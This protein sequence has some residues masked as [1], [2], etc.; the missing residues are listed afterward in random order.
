MT[1]GLLRAAQAESDG[2][3]GE[4]DFMLQKKQAKKTLKFCAVLIYSAA[5]CR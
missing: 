5:L 1:S 3:G 2:W 4:E